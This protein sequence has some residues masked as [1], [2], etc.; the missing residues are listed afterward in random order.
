METSGSKKRPIVIYDSDD[1]GGNSNNPNRNKAPSKRI[2]IVENLLLRLSETLK[3]SIFRDIVISLSPIEIKY[4]L[5]TSKI[6]KERCEGF[7]DEDFWL[8]LLVADFSPFSPL[9]DEEI[10]KLIK[11]FRYSYFLRTLTFDRLFV[12]MYNEFLAMFISTVPVSY[13]NKDENLREYDSRVSKN[14]DAYIQSYLFPAIFGSER[15][16][17]SYDELLSNT[18]EQKLY[19]RNKETITELEN[20][21]LNETDPDKKK[22]KL[23]IYKNMIA[24]VNYMRVREFY[25]V[26]VAVDYKTN[27]RLKAIGNVT[28]KLFDHPYTKVNLPNNIRQCFF[29]DI[30]KPSLSL[31]L[32]ASET[33]ES[34]IY[35]FP[36]LLT[37]KLKI[38]KPE[39]ATSVISVIQDRPFITK[40]DRN[41]ESEIHYIYLTIPDNSIN[42]ENK[43]SL[44]LS[45]EIYD[46]VSLNKIGINFCF[47]TGEESIRISN[48]INN[49]RDEIL[50]KAIN[51]PVI[52]RSDSK[53]DADKFMMRNIFNIEVNKNN[54]DTLRTYLSIQREENFLKYPPNLYGYLNFF[55]IDENTDQILGNGQL[56]LRLEIETNTI[57]LN[58]NSIDLYTKKLVNMKIMNGLLDRLSNKDKRI[59]VYNYLKQLKNTKQKNENLNSHAR[60]FNWSGKRSDRIIFESEHLKIETAALIKDTNITIE[61]V[62]FQGQEDFVL[63]DSDKMEIH[64]KHRFKKIEEIKRHLES[65][66]IK[67]SIC[68]YCN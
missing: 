5:Q 32:I 22:E 44:Q 47:F 12:Y 17:N 25:N 6:I 60:A 65:L 18:K 41:Y 53:K 15:K 52:S 38:N 27:D 51:D 13:L 21:Y 34:I 19:Y 56:N 68:P 48:E 1:D 33:E 67:D 50:E 59:Q 36:L 3:M 58:L 62:T 29:G 55:V 14:W 11:N 66:S 8:A 42:L 43:D 54:S 63:F 26:Q 49:K 37:S 16:L 23:R 20:S 46:I 30:K 57:A 28:K 7:I 40:G 2:K 31:P 24:T 9:E 45:Q 4:L 64:C 35:P 61:K 39:N 10:M